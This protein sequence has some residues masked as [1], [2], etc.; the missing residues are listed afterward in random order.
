MKT[1]SFESGRRN[2]LKRAAAGAV[3]LNLITAS[4]AISADKKAVIG[5]GEHT[6]ECEHF[7]GELPENHTYG[8]ATH[9]AAFDKQGLLYVTH[10]GGP[11]SV[12]VF[13]PNGKFVK[14]MIPEH[15]K[16]ETTGSGHGI[17]I[18]TESDGKEY[19]YLSPNDSSMAFTKATIEG[20]IVWT[21][22]K[23]Q[24]VK[25]SGVELKGYRPT[26][27]SWGPN[28]DVFLGDGYGSGYIFRYSKDGKF[29]SAFG[30]K[31]KEDGK[32]QTPH[33]QWLDD[34]DGTPKTVVCDRA[35]KRLQW[36]D[37]ENNHLKTMDGFLFPA[38]ID[39]MGDL[40]AVPDLHSRI[41]LLDKD[42]KVI[43]HLGNDEAW[44]SRVQDKA[45]KMRA[46]PDKWEE[47]KFVHPHDAAFDTDGNIFVVEWV[48]GGRVTK[49]RKV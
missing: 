16:S 8:G 3:G 40:M 29:L 37:M 35:N 23:A 4:K 30:G 46:S 25:E 31:G 13:D 17:D 9:G 44:H 41:T 10:H 2:F 47:G 43:S 5:S 1:S 6:Y 18:R 48:V 21:R 42:D 26:N 33:G 27:V 19:I 20:D 34:R 38:D 7:W 12:F 45:E 32:F 15:S 24:L 28:G 22:N 14:S 36:F 11:N 39:I 49:L